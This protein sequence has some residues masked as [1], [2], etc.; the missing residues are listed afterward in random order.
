METKSL[1]ANNKSKKISDNKRP[2]NSKAKT[3][4]K[5]HVCP[6]FNKC[7]GCDY[8]EHP[9][10]EQLEQKMIYVRKQLGDIAKEQKCTIEPIVGAA[11]PLYYRNK[12]HAVFA[13][14]GRG[15]II[16]GIYREDTHDVVNVSGCLL[17]NRTADA[18]IEE[19]K[20]LLP[21]FKLKVYDEDTGFGWLRHVLVRVGHHD[22]QDDIM[23]VLVTSEV[24]FPGKNN[25]IKAIRSRFPDITT[26][27]QNINGK[28]TSM[29]LGERNI[30]I[31]GKGWI[32]DNSLGL[33]FR[34]SPGAFYQINTE[35]TKILY[36]LAVDMAGLTGSEKVIDA[37]CGTGTIGMLMSGKAGRVTGI[38]LNHDAVR[39]AVSNMKA[40]GIKNVT[41][42]N[43]DATIYLQ[44]MA[45]EGE[46]ADVIVMD[47]PRSGSTPDFIRA[48]AELKAKRVVYV[49]CNP[50]TLARDLRA[51]IKLEY[52]VERIVPVDMFPATRHVETVVLLSKHS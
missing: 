3:E 6:Y 52:K 26:I 7:G 4:K 46:S 9:Y 30:V 37:Y 2:E 23:L 50:E 20:R 8:I 14:S 51:F 41:F 34:I 1:A 33:R 49:S 38:E 28:R 43:A 17:E 12:V 44:Q 45:A 13:R 31:F 11:N 18:I 35:Q 27:I 39:D 15:E 25:F 42:A 48:A 24:P 36:G 40:N 21:S 32:E 10:P 47:P 22:G 19:V 29:V 5:K 16:R